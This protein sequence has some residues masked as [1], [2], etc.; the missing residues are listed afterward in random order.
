[1][2]SF[3]AFGGFGGRRAHHYRAIPTTK[4]AKSKLKRDIFRSFFISAENL[5][6]IFALLQ[7]PGIKGQ[8]LRGEGEGGGI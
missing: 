8:A 7:G 3:G 4:I 1:M 2:G 5:V 6:I